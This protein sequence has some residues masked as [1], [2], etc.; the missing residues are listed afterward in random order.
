M[1]ER[2]SSGRS[3]VASAHRRQPNTEIQG[4]AQ[5]QRFLHDQHDHFEPSSSP[6]NGMQCEQPNIASSDIRGLDRL[7]GPGSNDYLDQHMEKYEA[8]VKKWSE[9]S[10]DEWKAGAE[11]RSLLVWFINLVTPNLIEI[12]GLFTKII[13]FVSRF[14]CLIVLC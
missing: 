12:S 13:D 1:A 8:S 3:S 4:H 2:P 7:L 11:R 10:L 5:P 9:C 6:S 14:F